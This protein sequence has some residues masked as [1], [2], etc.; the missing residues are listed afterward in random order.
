M[1]TIFE[2]KHPDMSLADDLDADW[3]ASIIICNHCYHDGN[4]GGR[5][6]LFNQIKHAY[7]NR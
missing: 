1:S 2:P 4:C 3:S 6:S 7:E 5:C